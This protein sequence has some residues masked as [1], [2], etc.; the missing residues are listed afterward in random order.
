MNIVI[1]N[2]VC[3]V[4][5]SR[6]GLESR[7]NEIGSFSFRSRRCRCR[8]SQTGL[9]LTPRMMKITSNAGSAPSHSM[10]RQPKSGCWLTSGYT[11]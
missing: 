10:T 9:S 1:I 5:G 2:D 6:L 11:N 8:S 4:T 3:S 7:V